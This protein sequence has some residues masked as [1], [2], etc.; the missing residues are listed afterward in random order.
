M[1]DDRMISDFSAIEPVYIDDCGGALNLGANLNLLFFRYAPIKRES[2][3]LVFERAP[4]LSLIIPWRSALCQ[5][6]ELFLSASSLY[7]PPAELDRQ[8]CLACN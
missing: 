6:P 8:A 3:Q 4:C 5:R 1:I 2:G 7:P